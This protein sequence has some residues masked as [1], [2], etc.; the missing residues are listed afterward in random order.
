MSTGSKIRSQNLAKF[1]Y[2][3]RTEGRTYREIATNI[4]KPVEQIKKMVLLG[5]RLKSLEEKES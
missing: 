4:N 1:A 5:E 3:L 2:V